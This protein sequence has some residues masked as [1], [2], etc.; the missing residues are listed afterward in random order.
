MESIFGGYL[1][2]DTTLRELVIDP[3]ALRLLPVQYDQTP[4]S[5]VA[6][7]Q[8]WPEFQRANSSL[9]GF[10]RLGAIMR[11][12]RLRRLAPSVDI[13][14]NTVRQ[15]LPALR[16][17]CDFCACSEPMSTCLLSIHPSGI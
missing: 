13:P 12:S 7:M 9:Y 1:G 6:V 15:L 4:P 5:I 3:N 11:P 16:T 10:H 2:F 8:W 17:S 14:G